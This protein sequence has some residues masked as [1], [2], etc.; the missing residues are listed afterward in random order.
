[1]SDGDHSSRADGRRNGEGLRT[2]GAPLDIDSADRGEP[3][4]R[5]ADIGLAPVSVAWV[6]RRYGVGA[7]EGEPCGY[8]RGER[9]V[10][11]AG[12]NDVP[13]SIL[14]TAPVV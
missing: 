5:Q 7:A 8:Q 4:A 3:S 13:P 9:N 1:M 6:G 14:R 11:Q 10:S 2:A 12:A